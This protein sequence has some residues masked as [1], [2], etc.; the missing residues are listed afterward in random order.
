MFDLW[1]RVGFELRKILIFLLGFSLSETFL[2]SL[3][4]YF[5]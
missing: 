5:L 1:K 2:G 3:S 4:Y